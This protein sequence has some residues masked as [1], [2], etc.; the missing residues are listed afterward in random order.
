M[1][2]FQP[3]MASAWPVAAAVAAALWGQQLQLS[4]QQPQTAIPPPPAVGWAWTQQN[5]GGKGWKGGKAWGNKGGQWWGKGRGKGQ[6][7]QATAGKGKGESQVQGSGHATTGERPAQ[8]EG[9]LQLW[10][11]K[12]REREEEEGQT[13]R[14]VS[15]RVTFRGESTPKTLSAR[16]EKEGEE[17]REGSEESQAQPDGGE[18][19]PRDDHNKEEE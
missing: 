18:G 10:R 1:N 9:L 11:G 16:F 6:P 8:E 7:Q 14:A 5:K 19:R 12:K 3:S 13:G 15:F 4:P 2:G 17:E